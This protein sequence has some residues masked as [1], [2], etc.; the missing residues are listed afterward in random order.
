MSTTTDKKKKTFEYPFP[1]PS[2]TVDLIIFTIIKGELC[3]LTIERKRPPHRGSRALPGGFL[4]VD[5]GETLIEAAQREAFEETNLKDLFIEQLHTFGDPNR[6]PRGRVITVAY[7]CLVPV[8]VKPVA[9]DDA[10]NAEWTPVRER[11]SLDMAF[12][13]NNIVNMASERLKGKIAYT[14]IACR[15]LP[16]R[17]TLSDLQLVYEIIL[18]HP[19]DRRNFRRYVV[20]RGIVL[21]TD[22]R[23]TGKHRPAKL[24]CFN[25][26]M[27]NSQLAG[28]TLKA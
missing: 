9:G 11:H 14:T 21:P 16:K 4:E 8:G 18:D 13:H 23:R 24:F 15:L 7:F 3:F 20:E 12:D 6:D 26:K 2:V 27:T 28:L 5:R 10:K 25:Q 17:F 1:M 22:E 19:L